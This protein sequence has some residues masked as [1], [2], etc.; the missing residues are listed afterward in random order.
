MGRLQ[1]PTKSS[2]SGSYHMET[3]MS[4]NET[5]FVTTE[6]DG[7]G[8]T[9]TFVQN[10]QGENI[11]KDDGRVQ[12]EYI[13]EDNFQATTVEIDDVPTDQNIS[14]H[15]VTTLSNQSKSINN[16]QPKLIQYATLTGASSLLQLAQVGT[17]LNKSGL[18]PASTS[19]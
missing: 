16:Q 7:A 4:D 2:Y 11:S 17:S 10:I 19:P 13:I 5:V 1:N 8:G 15:S 12:T 9:V 3:D 14:R 6:D 18:V